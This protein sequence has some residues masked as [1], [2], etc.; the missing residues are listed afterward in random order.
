MPR[1]VLHSSAYL[2]LLIGATWFVGADS[3]F[4]GDAGA[5][6]GQVYALRQGSWALE[7][8]LPVVAAEHEGWLNTA[9]NPEGPTPYTANP[10]YAQLLRG[11]V[12]VIHGPV[13]GDE[14]A[15]RLA[16][17]L[18]VVPIVAAVAGAALAWVV[19]A[20]YDRRAAPLAFWL[21][22]SGPTLVNGTTLWAHTLSTALGGAAVLA[23]L[24]ITE[25]PPT[26]T[27]TGASARAAGQ[28][29]TT[30]AI[31]GALAFAATTSA[32]L[33]SGPRRRFDRRFAA[34]ALLG[35]ALAAGAMVRTEALFWLLAVTAVAA[36]RSRDRLMRLAVVATGA[37]SGG[38]WL[39]NRQWGR[40]LRADRLPIETSI[41]ALNDT[42]GW[43]AGRLPAAWMLLVNSPTG[44]L[45]PALTVIG[46]SAVG[47]AVYRQL[48][49]VRGPIGPAPLL[50]LA[51]GAYLGRLILEPDATVSGV[52]GAWPA[53]VVAA[54]LGLGRHRRDGADDRATSNGRHGDGEPGGRATGSGRHGADG[55]LRPLLAVSLL[56]VGSVLATQ[57]ASSGGLQWGGR[58][59]AFSFVPL[60]VVAAVAGRPVFDRHRRPMIGLML[61]PA[62]LGL[63]ASFGLHRHHDAAISQASI[64]NP[65][66]VV[67]ESVALPR[68]AWRDLPI[69]YYRATEDDVVPLLDQLA[70]AGVEVV[71]VHGLAGHDLG[72]VT[73]Y[74][75]IDP[76]GPVRRLE[77]V[78]AAPGAGTG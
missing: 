20:R 15:G 2:L 19:A 12:R 57:Y 8:P 52:L 41:E 9:I 58:Y 56:L 32:A 42:P 51:V 29:A 44:G 71:N 5:Y 37:L 69:A 43:L 1:L 74:R 76:T 3:S 40:S 75:I 66:V 61:L 60:A 33:D 30:E 14:S 63:A 7:R 64:G 53:M 25:R 13:T 77:L 4:S 68:I 45:G 28:E 70:A 50:W 16:P 26:P 54:G 10:G 21:L 65:D 23:M 35:A 55:D 11:V 36:A 27:P 49:P 39:L 24:A 34:L 18:H 59:L 73:G 72:G 17:G 47:A 6:G 62:V 48:R 46:L 67:T 22:G 78:T 38:V 31:P